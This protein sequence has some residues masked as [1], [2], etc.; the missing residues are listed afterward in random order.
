[1]A[2]GVGMNDAAAGIDETHA[3]AETI[4][5]VRERR[6]LRCLQIKHSSDQNRPADMRNDQPHPMPCFVIN[7][8]VSLTAEDT[9]QGCAGCRFVENG[10]DEIDET[11]RPHPFPIKS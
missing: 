2:C 4:E 3:H 6:S 8:A 10:T 7:H 11:L 9:E 5:R 1:V